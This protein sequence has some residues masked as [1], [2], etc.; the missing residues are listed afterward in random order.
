MITTL[1]PFSRLFIRHSCSVV[2]Y[3]F[4]R[5][6]RVAFI[7]II[8]CS[9]IL[10]LLLPSTNKRTISRNSCFKFWLISNDNSPMASV[11]QYNQW[12]S[13]WL[14]LFNIN[15]FTTYCCAVGECCNNRRNDYKL[16]LT[17]ID[18][19]KIRLLII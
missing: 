12:K 10:L 5:V 4:F 14:D 9:G 15:I 16:W 8:A 13:E 2:F 18:F 19:L 7:F 6:I 1:T 11:F 17:F 3:T